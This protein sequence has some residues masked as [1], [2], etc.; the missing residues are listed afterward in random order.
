MV[1]EVT[2][3]PEDELCNLDGFD[4]FTD[5]AEGEDQDQFVSERIIQG[6]R[7]NFT[8]E[9]TWVDPSKQPL[10][11]NLELIA[12][13][14]IRVVQKWGKDNLPSEPPI[15]LEPNE[16]WPDVDVMNEKCPK[17]EWRERFGK[18]Q[19][20]YQKQR[21]VY[22]LDPLT[23]NKYT[24]A[25]SSNGGHICVSE[26]AEKTQMMRRFKKQRVYAVVKLSKALFSKRFGKYR[27]DLIVLR[28]IT[29]DGGDALPAAETPA[30]TGPT[31]APTSTPAAA[32]TPK[33]ALDQ[34]AGV[35][36]VTPP[37]AKEVTEDEIPF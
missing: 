2:K 34:F 36:I 29:L 17:T 25:T 33:E 24:F 20:P 14:I 3:K 28:W 1:N 8:N 26:I 13:N 23:M 19:G 30:I 37:T 5:E 9:A 12:V 18:L 35:K 11:V 4:G 22:L 21:V 16:K 7:I 10:S 27:P 31:T 32:T 6:V 15:I